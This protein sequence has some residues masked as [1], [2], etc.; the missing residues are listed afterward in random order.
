MKTA[1]PILLSLAVAAGSGSAASAQDAPAAEPVATTG[2]RASKVVV[3]DKTQQRN[4]ATKARSRRTMRP[5][6]LDALAESLVGGGRDL[7]TQERAKKR[8]KKQKARTMG[9]NPNKKKKVGEQGGDASGAKKNERAGGGGGD[10]KKVG[11]QQKQE[12]DEQPAKIQQEPSGKADDAKNGGNKKKDAT[13]SNGG[14][15]KKKNGGGDQR[16][17]R[18]L[19]NKKAKSYK[20]REQLAETHVPCFAS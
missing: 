5:A 4:A 16:D 11:G 2:L 15:K 3:K 14:G 7:G 19:Q 20:V 6:E 1:R 18:D 12:K 10:K 8:E 13:A 9:P 17:L